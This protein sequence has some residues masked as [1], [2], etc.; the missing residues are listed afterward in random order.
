MV[1]IRNKRVAVVGAGPAGL[2][3]ARLLQMQGADVTVYERDLSASAR[4]Q[5][6]TLDL[7]DDAGLKALR[8]ANLMDS[9]EA[10]YRPGADKITV[11]DR[12]GTS[13]L[14]AFV[15]SEHGVA[16]PEIDRGPLRDLLLNSLKQG[17]VKWGARFVSLRRSGRSVELWF[18]D[19]TRS[20]ADLVVAADGANSILRPYLTPIRPIYSGI[21]VLE[22]NIRDSAASVPQIHR[23]MDDGK[24]CALGDEK[25]LFVISKGDGSASF[26]TGHKA[27]N[28]WGYTSGIDFS[29]KSAVLAWFKA[30][31]VQWSPM[32]HGLFEHAQPPFVPRPQNYFP[33]DQRWEAAADLTMIG[34]AAHVMPPYAGEGVNMAMLD[35]LELA[36][37][38]ADDRF[39][40]I[41]WAI[42]SFEESM[43]L[44]T[45]EAT[46][47]TMDQTKA[48]HSAAAIPDLIQMFASH[49][50][51]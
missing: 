45:A 48:F 28:D 12:D 11:V 39:Q 4:P 36:Q 27:P 24:I 19:G 49:A 34:D 23:M 15:S 18:A 14:D 32:W 16:R 20:I 37:C 50:D 2:T 40:D 30:E 51:S 9:F 10:S 42:S 25:S 22:G 47:V 31:F 41:R 21:M 43:R 8:A 7:H 13:F 38:L 5:G 6:A 1:D 29:D 17:T 33:T 26:Y 3:L 35:A 46:T 44:R